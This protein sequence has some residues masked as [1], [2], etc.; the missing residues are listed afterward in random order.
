MARLP[1]YDDRFDRRFRII[2]DD[3]THQHK[4]VILV[5]LEEIDGDYVF[6]ARPLTGTTRLRT[7][8]VVSMI[9][10][11]MPLAPWPTRVGTSRRR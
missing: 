4:Q 7:K 11:E 5:F 2:Y 1:Q 8:D 10:T 3:G 6:D 9:E